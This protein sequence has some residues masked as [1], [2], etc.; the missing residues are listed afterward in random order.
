[1][2]VLLANFLTYGWYRSDMTAWNTI[3]KIVEADAFISGDII[4]S[5]IPLTYIAKLKLGILAKWTVEGNVRFQVPRWSKLSK[6][7]DE[8]YKSLPKL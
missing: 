8:Q 6:Y 2:S 1:M 3:M 7:I 5:M 4:H